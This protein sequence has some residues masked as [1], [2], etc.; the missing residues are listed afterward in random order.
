MGTQEF[1]MGHLEGPLVVPESALAAVVSKRSLPFI[2]F[3]LD[4]E[5]Y[6]YRAVHQR[7]ELEAALK[8]T[9]FGEL[10]LDFDQR[11]RLLARIKHDLDHGWKV[12][13][14]SWET[15]SDPQELADR[16][17]AGGARGVYLFRDRKIEKL[18]RTTQACPP[19]G[20]ARPSMMS[21]RVP[22]RSSFPRQALDEGLHRWDTMDQ[23]SCAMT[24]A[25]PRGNGLRV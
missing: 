2:Q 6:G 16:L 22:D 13:I 5:G 24:G 3:A 19:S 20:D 8:P 7:P 1:D 12:L 17:Y 18:G 23:I 14:I 21:A 4:R 10:A 15:Q 25:R 11:T 9:V